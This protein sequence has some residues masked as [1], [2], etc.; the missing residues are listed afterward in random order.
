MGS[1]VED[2]APNTLDGHPWEHPTAA[3]ARSFGNPSV[4]GSGDIHNHAR[5][6]VEKFST[7]F[8]KKVKREPAK[9]APMHLNFTD[10][11]KWRV[12]ANA[13]PARPLST[14]KLATLDQEIK[15]L[16]EAGVI[17]RSQATHY[18]QVLLVPKPGENKW[19]LCLDYRAL[20][21]TLE[22]MGWP[23]PNINQLVRKI[24]TKKPAW[25]AVLD[26]TSGYHQVLL[27][28]DSRSA[29]AF[30]TPMG[31]FEPV[32]MSMGL[33]SAPAY[34]QQQMQSVV[35]EGLVGQICELYIDD[36]IYGSTEQEFLTSSATARSFQYNDQSGKS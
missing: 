1:S 36:I 31:L 4:E 26:L 27:D 30:I 15:K 9:V 35:L 22:G 19:R 25:Y 28:E 6:L 3:T 14:Q 8:R 17:Q 21:E 33:K 16:L 20:N 5:Q 24:G 10:E 2:G 7:V 23:I 29:A 11:K 13:R 32:R 34:F 18:S 12:R